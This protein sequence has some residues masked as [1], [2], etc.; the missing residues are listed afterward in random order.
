ME[1]CFLFVVF[2]SNYRQTDTLTDEQND[3]QPHR[4]ADRL[5]VHSQYE[6]PRHIVLLQLNPLDYVHR[7]TVMLSPSDD[8][9]HGY[10]QHVGSQ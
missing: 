5:A 7:A 1:R 6:H 8:V 2:I 3:R 9:T 10:K 4:Q